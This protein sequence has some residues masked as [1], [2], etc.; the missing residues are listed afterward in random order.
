MAAPEGVDAVE[1]K[2]VLRRARSY[3]FQ[4]Q[5]LLRLM[6]NSSTRICPPPEQREALIEQSH[7]R[8]GHFGMRRTAGLIKLSYWWSGMHADVSSV[9]SRCKLCDRANTTGNVRPEELQPLPIK[10]PMYRWGVDLCGPFPETA[11]GDRY[12]MVAIEHFSKHI[13]LIPLPDKTAKSTAQAFLS[14][15]LARFSAPAEVLTD[16]GAEWQGEFA[17]L[18]E[19]CAID[20]RETSAEH[21][22]TDGAAERI[23]QVVKRG[24]RKYCAQEGRAQAWDEFLP[25][26]ALGYRCSPQASTRMT[27]YFLLYGVDPVVPPAV[28]ERFAEPLDPTNEQE[29]KRFLQAEEARQGR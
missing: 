11:R 10:G 24:L 17:A 5:E 29:F 26:M 23:V 8:L 21:P 25:W 1:L 13:E 27:P 2:R 20:H 22:Q 28:R 9:V 18:L 12:V 15:V 16:R 14:N 6:A 4:G 3:R 19:Q 7:R